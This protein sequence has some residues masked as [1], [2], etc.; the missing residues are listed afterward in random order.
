MASSDS[1]IQRP[2]LPSV[3]YDGCRPPIPTVTQDRSASLGTTGRHAPESV[4]GLPRNHWSACVGARPDTAT[5]DGTQRH[6]AH[7][8]R[9]GDSQCDDEPKRYA[10]ERQAVAAVFPF[11][12]PARPTP[13]DYR[14]RMTDVSANRQP[15]ALHCDRTARAGLARRYRADSAPT[16]CTP[17]AEGSWAQSPHLRG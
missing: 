8:L 10:D 16:A 2:S 13:D 3:D 15:N 7:T 5:R 12:S 6:A 11:T 1:A 17:D 14:H 9:P 4:V